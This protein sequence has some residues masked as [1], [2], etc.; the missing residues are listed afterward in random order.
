MASLDLALK[1]FK[2]MASRIKDQE[3]LTITE[4]ADRYC[5][6]VDGNKSDLANEYFSALVIR[7]WGKIQKA[8]TKNKVALRVSKEDCYDWVISSIM[9]ACDKSARI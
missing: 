9:M 5:E 8:Y 2:T 4:L 3:S 6:A 7:F 1:D